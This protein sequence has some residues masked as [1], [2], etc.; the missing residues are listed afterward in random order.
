MRLIVGNDETK[1]KL[2][3]IIARLKSGREIQPIGMSGPPMS[4]KKHIIKTLAQILGSAY[5]EIDCALFDMSEKTLDEW[6][7]KN[8]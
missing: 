4:G 5:V 7:V 3:T 1:K 8:D 6:K 2:L